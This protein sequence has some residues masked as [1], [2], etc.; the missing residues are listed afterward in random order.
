MAFGFGPGRRGWAFAG[1]DGDP[2]QAWRI[3][4]A[5]WLSTP[6]DYSG[7]LALELKSLAHT[8]ALHAV[9]TSFNG[10]YVGYVVPAKYYAMNSNT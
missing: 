5:L 10:D 9:V 4:D 2:L 8:K 1:R 7:E 6:C 3:G